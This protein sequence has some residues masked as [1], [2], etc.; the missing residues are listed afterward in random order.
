M[1]SRGS[2]GE[3]QKYVEVKPGEVQYGGKDEPAD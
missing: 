2:A 1:A 3:R